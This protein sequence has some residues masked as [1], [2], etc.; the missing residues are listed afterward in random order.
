M[1]SDNQGRK[2]TPGED[3]LHAGASAG[4]AGI[5]KTLFMGGLGLGLGY[6]VMTA[7]RAFPKIYDAIVAAGKESIPDT[8]E[9]TGIML[10][11]GTALGLYTHF[12][13]NR[14]GPSIS[15]KARGYHEGGVQESVERTSKRAEDRAI[16]QAQENG[17]LEGRAGGARLG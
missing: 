16:R 1:V 14:Q 4:Y 9:E 7:V 8:L 2:F 15:E 12:V 6:T 17:G 10:L 11:A 5:K 13:R 3:L